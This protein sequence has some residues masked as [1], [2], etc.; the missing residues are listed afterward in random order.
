MKLLFTLRKF[1][2]L[3]SLMVLSSCTAVNNYY[4]NVKHTSSLSMFLS[5][6]EKL[7]RYQAIC[8]GLGLTEESESWE[9]CLIETMKTHE[10]AAARSSR[11]NRDAAM[12]RHRAASAKA[13][14]CG[15]NPANC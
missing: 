9:T 1:V 8:K 10:A 15:L 11:A 7:E 14:A 6:E 13:S 4:E 5:E 3:S 12:E 2:L